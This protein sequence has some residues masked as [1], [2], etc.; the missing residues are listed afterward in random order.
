MSS[1][2]EQESDWDFERQKYISS[3]KRG[4]PLG[5]CNP[6]YPNKAER[7][8]LVQIMQKSGLTEE[9]VRK[10]PVHRR[11]LAKARQSMS[12]PPFDSHRYEILI[13]R[14]KR[15][16]AAALGVPPYDPQVEKAMS[17]PMNPYG[18]T[19]KQQIRL[20]VFESRPVR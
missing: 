6:H 20:A 4:K 5:P 11:T 17:T 12:K 15:A 19:P 10:N 1:I 2:Y 13:K 9:E 7:K 3:R 14:R 8:A 18:L 16:I